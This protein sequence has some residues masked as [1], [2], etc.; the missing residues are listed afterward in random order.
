MKLL[1]KFLTH[2]WGY[3]ALV[4]A[5]PGFFLHSLGPPRRR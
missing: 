5:V 4:I 1:S 2:F 3:F